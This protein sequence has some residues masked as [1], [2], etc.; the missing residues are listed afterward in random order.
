MSGFPEHISVMYVEQEVVFLSLFHQQIPESQD[1][2][3]T[4]VLKSNTILQNLVEEKNAIETKTKTDSASEVEIA[5]LQ[6]I[7]QEIASRNLT[8]PEVA[9]CDILKG[10]GFTKEMI[11]QPTSTLSGGWRMR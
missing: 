11:N 3:L 2:V 10:L 9:A 1:S 8:N 6:Q 5:R 7:Y 4:Q